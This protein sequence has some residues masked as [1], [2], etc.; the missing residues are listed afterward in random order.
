MVD[1]GKYIIVN[2]GEWVI[3]W[4]S[5]GDKPI[6]GWFIKENPIKIRMI[7]GGTPI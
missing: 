7:T 3:E 2:D 4:V 6:A 5:M 1:D